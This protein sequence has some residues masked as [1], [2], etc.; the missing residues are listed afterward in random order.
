MNHISWLNSCFAKAEPRDPKH[1]GGCPRDPRFLGGDDKDLKALA[2]FKSDTQI[3][4][5][6]RLL[7][8]VGTAICLSK[9]LTFLS[10]LISWPE[11]IY[12]SFPS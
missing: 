12:H 7:R 10:S 8:D 1:C 4:A 2:D 3:R 6:Y 9:I 11:M 5:K